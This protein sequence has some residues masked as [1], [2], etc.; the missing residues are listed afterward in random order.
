MAELVSSSY[1]L[2]PELAQA[3]LGITDG[4]LRALNEILG[5]DLFARGGS[6]MLRGPVDKVA[7]GA[8]VLSELEAMARR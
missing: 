3:V 7:H 6:V 5:I 4:N 1:E 2:D 8:R